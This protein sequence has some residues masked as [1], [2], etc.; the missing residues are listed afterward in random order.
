MKITNFFIIFCFCFFTVSCNLNKNSLDIDIGDYD[1]Q[2]AAWNNQNM[3]DYQ[4]HVDYGINP[5]K[6]FTI[7]VK[8]GVFER[9]NPLSWE[10]T[11]PEIFSNIKRMEKEIKDEY[12][13]MDNRSLSL[14]VSYN[15]EYHY[16]RSIIQSVDGRDIYRYYIA[17]MPLADGE[18]D[19]DIGDYEYH[20][21]AWSNQNML[22]YQIKVF[23][24]KGTYN[25]NSVILIE[26]FN[27]KNGIP[28]ISDPISEFRKTT[29]I[30]AI[31]SF[32]KEQEETIKNLYNGINRSYLHIQYD[33][34]Y[35][36]PKQIHSG[37]DHLFGMYNLREIV[38]T[39]L[40]D[41]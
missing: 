16:P 7:T 30:P 8:D 35:H 11:I 33:T 28:D 36:Y 6:T 29:T 41:K 1:N 25:Y 20:L 24:R 37:A 21:E 17:L 12:N 23:Y 27:I 40:A 4:L 2:L 9:T 14:K 38:L 22:D 39:P 15:T 19:I 32:I 3:L 13:S 31:F 10:H 5:K 34:E 26:T 18:L